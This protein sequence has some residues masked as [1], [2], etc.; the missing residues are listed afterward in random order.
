MIF[1]SCECVDGFT[2]P[3]CGEIIDACD[4][5]PCLNGGACSR[6][7]VFGVGSPGFSCTC[8]PGF[9]G[10]SCEIEE[11]VG[12]EL[13]VSMITVGFEETSEMQ[14]FD[15]N[16]TT[17]RIEETSDSSSMIFVISG[18]SCVLV[19]AGVVFIKLKV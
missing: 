8:F 6:L 4:F 11:S 19:I 10:V 16:S 13:E 1:F 7:D 3:T 9:T 15:L 5:E 17:T 12:N 14:V 18:G 2:G